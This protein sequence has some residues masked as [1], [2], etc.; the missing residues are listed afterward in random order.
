MRKQ[1]N[2]QNQDKP[3]C[4]NIAN[5]LHIVIFRS[6]PLSRQ[7]DGRRELDGWPSRNATLCSFLS[8]TRPSSPLRVNNSWRPRPRSPSSSSSSS[9]PTIGAWRIPLSF[10][11]SETRRRA[12]SKFHI[13]RC[14]RAGINIKCS[15][16]DK[17]L[18]AQY[19][20]TSVKKANDFYWLLRKFTCCL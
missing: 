10:N 12:G 17:G 14:W 16:R 18:K 7:P 6:L 1:R 3:Y 19:W 20:G 13:V 15:C 2:R 11:P 4:S 8:S 9:T 5:S